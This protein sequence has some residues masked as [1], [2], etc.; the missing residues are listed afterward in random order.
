[1]LFCNA[2][3]FVDFHEVDGNLKG[4]VQDFPVLGLIQSMYIYLRYLVT[5]AGI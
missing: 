5:A 4:S 3:Q 1:M 2:D